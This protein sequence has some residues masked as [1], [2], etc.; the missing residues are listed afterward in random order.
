MKAREIIEAEYI[1]KDLSEEEI[2]ELFDWTEGNKKIATSSSYKFVMLKSILDCIIKYEK[3]R[4]S[5]KEIF[6]RFT[7]IYWVLV[8]QYGL[9]QTDNK[10][11]LPYVETI[12]KEY[13][14]ENNSGKSL[15]LKFSDLNENIKK[16]IVDRVIKDCKQVVF[17]A[18]Y[19]DMQGY[20]YSFSKLKEYV[21]I[22]PIFIKCIKK[23]FIEIENMI[24][25]GLAKYLYRVN[26]ENKIFLIKENI[27]TLSNQDDEYAIYK[28]LFYK[29]F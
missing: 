22:N 7:Q 3:E 18:L 8:G 12:I 9:E 29:E 25:E 21:I 10:T 23:H 16:H 4:F 27:D 28:G 26:D 5:F 2:I 14:G 15:K 11:R 17:G 19:K 13:I 6:E 1:S 20:M 24:Y